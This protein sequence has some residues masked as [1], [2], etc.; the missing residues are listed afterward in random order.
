MSK[1]SNARTILDGTEI[2]SDGKWV[3]S[4]ED[5]KKHFKV[6]ESVGVDKD[7]ADW[8]ENAVRDTSQ[9]VQTLAELKRSDA[10]P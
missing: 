8:F 10:D 6:D 7:N 5:G 4:S 2:E 9:T 1:S 3:P